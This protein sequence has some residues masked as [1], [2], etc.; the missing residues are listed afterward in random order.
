MSSAGSVAPST[1]ELADRAVRF[2][3]QEFPTAE[4][5]F[6]GGSVASGHATASSDLDVLVLLPDRWS[7]A[8]F[9]HTT[10]FEGQLVETFAYGRAGLAQWL[11]RGR[12]ARRPVLDRLIAEGLPLLTGPITEELR[13]ESRAV[14]A[15]GPGPAD[16]DDL[17]RRAYSIS[18]HLDD[19]ADRTGPGTDPAEATVLTWAVWQETAELSLL[20]GQ[21]WLGTGK[22]L[23]REIRAS[24]DP[25]GLAAWAEHRPHL[26]RLTGIAREVLEQVG[27]HHQEGF[28]RGT[29][30][31]D[32]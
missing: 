9:V 12:A 28:L 16:P 4:A 30:P 2:V 24:G 19:L 20:V 31:R 11:E 5:G 22:W 18:A 26:T 21:Q 8:A 27:G 15:A 32:L 6:L 13:Q 10:R 23:V 3:R 29:R 7:D 17:A 1:D 25:F 14:L